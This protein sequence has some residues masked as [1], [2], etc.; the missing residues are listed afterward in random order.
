MNKLIAGFV[1][2][3]AA[4]TANASYLYWQVDTGAGDNSASAFSYE[5][6]RIGYF[7]TSVGANYG[8]LAAMEA[9]SPA[10]IGYSSAYGATTPD[11]SMAGVAEFQIDVPTFPDPNSYS[12]F[13]ELVNYNA[14]SDKYEHVAYSEVLTY[15]NLV[16]KNYVDTGLKADFVPTIWH[17]GTFNA[18]PE[19]TGALLMVLGL[20]FLGLKRRTA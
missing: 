11:K 8:D 7:E 12:F 16:G 1:V 14:T 4:V 13:I 17:G 10:A 6:A 18:V 5:G 3:L 15:D 19:P 20:A 2:A 9:G